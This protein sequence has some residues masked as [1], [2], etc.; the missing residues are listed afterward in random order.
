VGF[1]LA[2]LRGFNSY[3]LCH[4]ERARRFASR[5]AGAVGM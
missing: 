5:I 1:I 4:P 3:Q 2:P